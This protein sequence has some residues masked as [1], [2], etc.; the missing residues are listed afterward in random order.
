MYRSRYD[1]ATK[2]SF[3]RRLQDVVNWTSSRRRKSDFFKTSWRRCKSDV[4]KMSQIRRLQDDVNQTSSRREKSSKSLKKMFF[5]KNNRDIWLSV[6]LRFRKIVLLH[7]IINKTRLT[8]KQE[9]SA[10]R[11]R[12]NY[13]TD[14][15][16]KFLQ[17]TIEP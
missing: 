13:I 16:V 1:V 3:Y 11:F 17:D 2:T 8:K 9:N 5:E 14:H 7:K 10:H 12:D 15:I 6:I 4:F